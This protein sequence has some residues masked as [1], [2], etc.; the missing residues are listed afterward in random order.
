MQASTKLR[1]VAVM[2]FSAMLA[3]CGH[4][5]ASSQ[6]RLVLQQCPTTVND[7]GAAAA[8]S[9]AL[10]YQGHPVSQEVLQR[11]LWL[12]DGTTDALKMIESARR[13]G[14]K[15]RGVKVP[16]KELLTNLPVGSIL[17]REG[18]RF[19]VLEEI[20]GD[21]ITVLDPFDGRQTLPIDGFWTHFKNIV[22]LFE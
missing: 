11:E 18:E 17:Y 10:S 8:L 21:R 14:V 4:Q 15:A 6:R 7:G 12:P 16:D 1:R 13:H 9:M 3:A 20:A 19:Q 5:P 2:L 22:L